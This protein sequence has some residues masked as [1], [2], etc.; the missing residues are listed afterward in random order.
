MAFILISFLS[1]TWQEA[2]WHWLMFSTCY[3]KNIQQKSNSAAFWY[4]LLIGLS[5]ED[6]QFHVQNVVPCTTEN[7][8]EWICIQ[9]PSDFLHH[10][11]VLPQKAHLK[12]LLCALNS[13]LKKQCSALNWLLS[14]KML[15]P[16]RKYYY[17]ICTNR[18]LFQLCLCTDRHLF[19]LCY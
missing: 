5:D 9:F 1:K 14:T 10:H 16:K 3:S 13:A 12:Y 2:V 8:P 4:K 17:R 7:V 6:N 15:K 11:F 18:H 19:Q